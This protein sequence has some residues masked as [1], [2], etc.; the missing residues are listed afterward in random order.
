[1]LTSRWSRYVGLMPLVSLSLAACGADTELSNGAVPSSAVAAP[2]T[3]D[4]TSVSSSSTIAETSSTTASCETMETA[5]LSGA[6]VNVPRLEMFGQLGAS[7]LVI[8]TAPDEPVASIDE[9][10]ESVAPSLPPDHPT[11]A[12][13]VATHYK[14]TIEQV[15]VWPDVAPLPKPGEVHSL[16]V[17]GGTVDCYTLLVEDAVQ[18]RR[19]AEYVIVAGVGETGDLNLWNS[20]LAIDV[21]DGTISETYGGTL[22]DALKPLL[23]ESLADL[24]DTIVVK[25]S[26]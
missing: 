13:Y 11:S 6:T 19:N 18:V 16:S 22:P 1:M 25:S 15:V 8:K 12:P 24:P 5:Q 23:G 2:A 21:S 3:V 20:S 7:V 9:S 10:V 26:I 17:G 4:G 14:V